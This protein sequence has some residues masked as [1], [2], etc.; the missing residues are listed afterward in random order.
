MLAMGRGF[1]LAFARSEHPSV[2]SHLLDEVRRLLPDGDW[3][4][5][6]LDPASP[7]SVVTQ[8]ERAAASD[9]DGVFVRGLERFIDLRLDRSAA[10]AQLNLNREHIGA[11]LPMRVVILL[12]GFAMREVMRYAPDL[13]SWRS[14]TYHLRGDAADVSTTLRALG[15]EGSWEVAPAERHARIEILERM[16]MEMREGRHEQAAE[17]DALALL[18]RLRLTYSNPRAAAVALE[19]ALPIY[20]QIGARLGEA[21]TLYQLG[22]L[23][24]TA[25]RWELAARFSTAAYEIYSAIGHAEWAERARQQAETAAASAP[26]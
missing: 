2:F 1:R 22:R 19:E 6:E 14:G 10:L 21:N 24:M 25:R 13:W 15:E 9:A 26:G 5:V 8:L 7:D 18:A 4:E 12:P 3:R 23:A 20:R 17:A 16:M 11:T